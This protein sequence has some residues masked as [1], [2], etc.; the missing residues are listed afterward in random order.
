MAAGIGNGKANLKGYC[1][2]S[3]F[4]LVVNKLIAQP[5]IIPKTFQI[6]TNLLKLFPALKTKKIVSRKNIRLK[7]QRIFSLTK[8]KLF[9]W[10][11]LATNINRI[12]VKCA[13]FCC[14]CDVVRNN[15]QIHEL[16]IFQTHNNCI[17][18][19]IYTTTQPK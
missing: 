9:S 16:I 18:P 10:H 1:P 6:T 5:F 11:K 19:W 2:H 17:S 3:H 8:K 4:F 14:C 12:R 7:S 15:W 13:I